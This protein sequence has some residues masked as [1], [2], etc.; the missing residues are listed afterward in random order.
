[1][2]QSSFGLHPS[3]SRRRTE[4]VNQRLGDRL[5]ELPDAE[6]GGLGQTQS[7]RPSFFDARLAPVNGFPSS[8]RA[9]SATSVSSSA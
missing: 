8:P 5:V 1:M 9:G 3:L 4:R 6:R 7:S 2:C